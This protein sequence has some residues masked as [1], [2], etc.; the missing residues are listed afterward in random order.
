[1][2]AGQRSTALTMT[3]RISRLPPQLTSLDARMSAIV[4]A[5]TPVATAVA[6]ASISIDASKLAAAARLIADADALL[7]CTGA[8]MGVASGYGTFRGASAGVWPPL[9]KYQPAIPFQQVSVATR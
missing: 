3:R 6:A 9:L 5:A 2:R 4:A 7:I 8:G 1:M